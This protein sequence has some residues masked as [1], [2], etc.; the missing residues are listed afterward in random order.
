MIPKQLDRDGAIKTRVRGA[1]HLTM[2]PGPRGRPIRTAQSVIRVRVACI[3]G[4][5]SACPSVGPDTGK[6]RQL[7]S[8]DYS[9]AVERR[10]FTGAL[11]HL[12]QR[13]LTEVIPHEDMSHVNYWLACSRD[14]HCRGEEHI[15]SGAR[16][17]GEDQ[18]ER[19]PRQS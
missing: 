18:A 13:K 14:G 9:G 11:A 5:P 4:R 6:P 3:Q 2:P 10:L 7:M 19:V 17:R 8:A 12:M 1:I 15:R 16:G